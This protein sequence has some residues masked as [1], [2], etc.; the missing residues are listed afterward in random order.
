MTSSTTTTSSSQSTTTQ[1]ITITTPSRT[2]EFQNNADEGDLNPSPINNEK[3]T[4]NTVYIAIGVV[5]GLC[6]LIAVIVFIILRRKR[7]DSNE[8]SEESSSIDMPEETTFINDELT[9]ETMELFSTDANEFSDPFQEDFEE[10]LTY[11]V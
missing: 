9:G 4:N 7:Q 2:E 5:I 1:S 8:E 6:I 11:R 3:T 10:Q